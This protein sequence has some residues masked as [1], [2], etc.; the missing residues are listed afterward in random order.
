MLI[1]E[2]NRRLL[3]EAI[4]H[5]TTDIP[6]SLHHITI[7][8]GEK[9]V[10]YVHWHTELE[11][12]MVHNGGALFIIE[13]ETIELHENEAVF[14]NS[15]QLHGARALNGLP[16][17]FYAVVF[18][19]SLLF[20]DTQKVSFHHYVKPILTRS[21]SYPKHII[22]ESDPDQD[23]LTLLKEIAAISHK[24]IYEHELYVR[25][26]LLELWHLFYHRCTPAQAPSREYKID[27]LQPVLEYISSHYTEVI[28]IEKLASLI[29]LSQGQ[30]CRSF[31]ET[32][33]VSPIT[34]LNKYRVMKSCELLLTTGSKISE[35]AGLTGFDNVSYYNRTFLSM[36]GCTPSDYQ[37]QAVSQQLS[38]M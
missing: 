16:C 10:L 2:N 26:K 7:P 24:N 5:G 28:T 14:I 21:L 17:E 27:R 37:R 19:P 18:H 31:K 3:K 4:E 6:F 9:Q 13:E 20:G 12:L 1:T 34:Y 33:G 22:Q 25:G 8:A 35:I 29:P 32:L 23:M 38:R 11:F 30:F 15:H 36:I